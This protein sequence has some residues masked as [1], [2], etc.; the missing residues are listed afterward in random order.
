MR[1]DRIKDDD[2]RETVEELDQEKQPNTIETAL[3]AA[4]TASAP[5]LN[6]NQSGHYDGK[7]YKRVGN[8]IY[9]FDPD[10]TITV[11]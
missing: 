5:L 8:T 11:T 1:T 3:D 9:R 10:E 4:P 2:T 6:A 7:Y